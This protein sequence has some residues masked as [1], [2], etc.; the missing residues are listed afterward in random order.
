M[1]VFT[2][3]GTLLFIVGLKSNHPFE[4]KRNSSVWRK[5]IGWCLIILGA[6]NI[7]I[8]GIKQIS[9]N[10]DIDFNSG[11][12]AM[13]FAI[14]IAFIFWGIYIMTSIKLSAPIWKRIV[15]GIIYPMMTFLLIGSALPSYETAINSL[16]IMIIFTILTLLLNRKSKKGNNYEEVKVTKIER[17]DRDEQIRFGS[18]YYYPSLDKSHKTQSQESMLNKKTTSHPKPNLD[19]YSERKVNKLLHNIRIIL[20]KILI[21]LLIPCFLVLC[22][23]WINNERLAG[24]SIFYIP[25]FLVIL[26]YVEKLLWQK[27]KINGMDLLLIPWFQKIS[28]FKNEIN[29]R[30]IIYTI[31]PSL[32]ISIL[33]PLLSSFLMTQKAYGLCHFFLIF[34][35]LCWIATFA[36]NYSYEWIKKEDQTDNSDWIEESV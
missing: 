7:I 12:Y 29:R 36:I 2:F 17:T 34:P 14:S 6:I 11:S 10:G 16:I 3:F 20:F 9:Y 8:E 15:L 28:L 5:V 35:I 30:I 31:V 4:F 21:T 19:N 27:R 23:L 26:I 25:Y 1:I 22:L 13:G 24:W 18:S 33:F 32:L